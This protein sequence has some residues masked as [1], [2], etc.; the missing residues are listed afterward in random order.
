MIR[1]ELL[2]YIGISVAILSLVLLV[3]LSLVFRIREYKLNTVFDMEYGM[4]TKLESE[5]VKIPK[6]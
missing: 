2:F 5:K 4:E 1:D 3:I 6:K